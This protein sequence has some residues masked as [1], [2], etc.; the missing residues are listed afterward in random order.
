MNDEGAQILDEVLDT[1]RQF[2]VFQNDHDAV[3]CALHI[4]ATHSQTAWEHATRLVL[5]SP[6]KR[7]GKSRA[8][9]IHSSLSHRVLLTTNISVAA[10]VHSITENDPPT[11]YLDEADTVFGAK[12]GT[13]HEDLRGILNAGFGRERPYMRYDPRG[14][15]VESLPTFCMAVLA[16]I[17]DMPDTIEDRA[18]VIKLRRRG[19]GEY[20]R[21]YR[22]R[23]D[24][25]QL[26]MLRDKLHLWVQ[27]VS[28][29]LTEAE[30]DMPVD[31]RDADKWEPLIA[32]ADAAGGRWP[33]LS[34]W[35]CATVCGTSDD[36]AELDDG[37]RLLRDIF[38]VFNGD[39]RLT[40][41]EL[42]QRLRMLPEGGWGIGDY[43]V[44]GLKPISLA[45]LL[46]PYGISSKTLRIDKR[47][48]K[49]FEQS[50]FTEAWA[51]YCAS[52]L[53]SDDVADIRNTVFAGQGG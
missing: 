17:G 50:Q 28:G 3:A 2:V 20:V 46:R 52:L 31:D 7:C 9:D 40:T 36:G 44:K 23:R 27:T 38:V 13:D 24:R 6:Q 48:P 21:P 30:P 10:L 25:P 43:Q 32:V 42:I 18:V 12:T 16:G 47:T 22:I 49:G 53:V 4:A 8:M 34:R 1:L 11:V 29:A 39:E 26:A 51:R 15:V 14:N 33:G 19:A 35:A 45:A 5:K 37:V 41:E